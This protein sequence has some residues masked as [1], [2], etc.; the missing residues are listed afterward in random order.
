MDRRSAPCIGVVIY[1]LLD[2]R[3]FMACTGRMTG[4]TPQVEPGTGRASSRVIGAIVAVTLGCLMLAAAAIVQP[5]GPASPQFERMDLLIAGL[6]VATALG[7]RLGH[8]TA[9]AGWRR[10]IGGGLAFGALLPPIALFVWLIASAADA[11]LRGAANPLTALG[12][13]SAW[14]LFG[15]GIVV[16]Y[17][18]LFTIPAGLVWALIT[19]A[20]ARARV[21]SVP[22]RSRR[23][24]ANFMVAL[25]VIALG[26]GTAQAVAYAPANARCFDLAGGAPTDAAFSPAGDLL[27]ITLQADPNAPGTIVLMRWPSAEVVASW[28][29][30]V[31]EEV[32]V[33]PAGRVYWSAWVLGLSAAGESGDGVYSAAP[34]AD[35]IL[36][37]VGDERQLNDLTWTSI[38][39][40]GTTPNSHQI[41]RIPLSGGTAIEIDHSQD[42]IGAFWS[43]ADG[44]STIVGPGYFGTML[45]VTTPAGTRSV[46]ISG[47]ARSVALSADHRTIVEASWFDGTRLIDVESG[48][49]RPVLRGSQLFVALSEKGDLAWANDE[50]FGRGRLC[51][52]TLERMG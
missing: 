45:E 14:F 25:L 46:P 34:G 23:P 20:L 18:S 48:T 10:A 26:A 35:P 8:G 43:S 7:W 42:E 37:A 52:S 29:G 33:D 2:R 30:W 21:A 17:G 13:A 38:G 47:D 51:T 49:T 44:T 16:L 5:F 27:A 40:R 12:P 31:D 6:A 15:L 50:Q 19:R 9:R 1:V 24:T 41:A 36:F 22:R 39:L 11:V 3:T 28:S 32:A 4:G